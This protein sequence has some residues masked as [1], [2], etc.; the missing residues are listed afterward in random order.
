MPSSIG[1]PLDTG[2]G[3]P[4]NC[5]TAQHFLARTEYSAVNARVEVFDFYRTRV[6]RVN[7]KVMSW[8]RHIS[9][10][11]QFF[12][13]IRQILPGKATDAAKARAWP[14]QGLT[15]FDIRALIPSSRIRLLSAGNT[16][17][18]HPVHAAKRA[19]QPQHG[20]PADC[21]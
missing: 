4:A 8:C 21:H 13:P 6:A 19:R 3:R 9:A 12:L 5:R 15:Q 17:K 16:R 7:S 1:A 14:A 11:I 18:P 2:L 10:D 20:P